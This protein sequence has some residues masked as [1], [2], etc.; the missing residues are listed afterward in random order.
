MGRWVARWV[1]LVLVVGAIGLGTSHPAQACSCIPLTLAELLADEELTVIVGSVR[2]GPV[3]FERF[4]DAA[5]VDITYHLW[6]IDVSQT[7]GQDVESPLHV[8][9]ESHEA[10][11]GF[12]SLPSE[13]TGFVLDQRYTDEFWTGLC[14]GLWDPSEVE[15]AVAERARV[16]Q[17]DQPADNQDG[18]SSPAKSP[19]A[20]GISDGIDLDSTDGGGDAD[21]PNGVGGV[22]GVTEAGDGLSGWWFVPVLL[23]GTG[24]VVRYRYRKPSVSDGAPTAG[25][26]DDTEI[27][28]VIGDAEGEEE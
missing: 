27:L 9:T 6:I 19:P 15:A 24:I 14:M 5:L 1:L 8:Y 22:A 11:C 3:E 12:T 25:G 18:L 21:D 7:Y 10:S 20:D 13:P 2:E 28:P 26:S 4:S 17:N 23:I 16:G